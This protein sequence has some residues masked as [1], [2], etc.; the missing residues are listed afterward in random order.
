ML[1]LILQIVRDRKMADSLKMG[2]LSLNESQH[3]PAPPSAPR[4]TSSGRTAYIPPHMRRNNMGMNMDGATPPPG[5]G[6][7][8]PRYVFLPPVGFSPKGNRRCMWLTVNDVFFAEA[9]VTG[10]MPTISTP[11]VPMVTLAGSLLKVPVRPLTQM[12]T[13][14]QVEV[15][16]PPAASNPKDS[17]MAS[18]VTASTSLVPKTPV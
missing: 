18:G 3:A 12:L 10:Q 14:S 13:E 7:W 17:A 8:A 15:M 6:S 9:V 4:T 2:N 16:A 11:V 5:P 1:T